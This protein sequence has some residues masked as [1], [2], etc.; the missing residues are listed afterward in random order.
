[1]NDAMLREHLAQAE[2][3]VA[4]GER[5]IVGQMAIIFKLREDG[6]DTTKAVRLL[7]LFEEL[8]AEHVA[9]RARLWEELGED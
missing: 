9:D 8:Q 2:R 3:Q 5:Y 7:R 6:H 4:Q 1:M